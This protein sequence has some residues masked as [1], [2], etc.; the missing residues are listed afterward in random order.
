M[1][2]AQPIRILFSMFVSGK[3]EV[4]KREKEKPLLLSTIFFFF[5]QVECTLYSQKIEI[6]SCL[7]YID[8]Y[9]YVGLIRN[10][11]GIDFEGWVGKLIFSK[12]PNEH[13]AGVEG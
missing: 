3:T 6:K 11:Y 10:F 1:H 13:V 4:V 5:F 12:L 7:H 8:K 9:G 2:G